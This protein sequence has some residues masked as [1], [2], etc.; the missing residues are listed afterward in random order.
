MIVG[1]S[2]AGNCHDADSVS[3][4]AGEVPGKS[5]RPSAAIRCPQMWVSCPIELSSLFH[6][7][8]RFPDRGSRYRFGSI[9]PPFAVWQVRG[10]E[11]PSLNGPY[12]VAEVAT[13]MHCMFSA[14]SRTV[15]YMT[16]WP[17]TAMMPGA[18]VCPDDAHDGSTGSGS[19]GLV[20]DCRSDELMT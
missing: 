11:E 15:K 8:Y 18:Q 17:P 4:R 19:T 9:E 13:E 6:S 7:R 1:P 5:D 14:L 10:P 20:H 12:A 16:N 3:S 2:T